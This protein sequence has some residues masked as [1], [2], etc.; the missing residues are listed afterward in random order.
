[1]E[2]RQELLRIE[3]SWHS[4][5]CTAVI[6]LGVGELIL[7]L[8]FSSNLLQI[9]ISYLFKNLSTARLAITILPITILDYLGI[10]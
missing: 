10:A 4:T 7:T 8:V 2:T 1:M 6:K 9:E 3:S 5:V